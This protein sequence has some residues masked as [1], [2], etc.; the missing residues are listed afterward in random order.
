MTAAEYVIFCG[1]VFSALIPLTFL[2]RFPGDAMRYVVL[3]VLAS[4]LTDLTLSFVVKDRYFIG[5]TIYGF[6]ES[7]LLFQFFLLTLP[8]LRRV[9][10]SIMCLFFVFYM[11]SAFHLEAGKFNTYA[12]SLESLIMICLALVSF[13]RFYHNE[14]DIFLE[15]SSIFWVNVAVILYFSGAFFSFI[16]SPEILGGP[17]PWSFFHVSNIIKNIFFGIAVF[18]FNRQIKR[19]HTVASDAMTVE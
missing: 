9:I 15:R 4:F 6:I 7:F 8:K 11:I 10:I 1:S 18:Q 5:N 19:E 13:Y 17:M 14:D 3:L 2:R 16:L 12:C